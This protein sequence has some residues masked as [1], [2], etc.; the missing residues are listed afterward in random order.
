MDAVLQKV[1]Y[2]VSMYLNSL[3]TIILNTII[4]DMHISSNK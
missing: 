1:Q 4:Q 3:V 2:V